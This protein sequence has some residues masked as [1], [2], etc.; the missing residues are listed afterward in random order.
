MISFTGYAEEKFAV[1]N[2]H[3]VFIR[4]EQVIAAL[5]TSDCLGRVGRHQ[6][7]EKDGLKV[8]YTLENN[9]QR[10]LTFYPV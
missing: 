8:V 4:K 3:G 6:S 9:S 1:L 5:N 2:R 7:A 10:V